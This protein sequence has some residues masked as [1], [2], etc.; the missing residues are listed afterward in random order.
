MSYILKSNNFS[1]NKISKTLPHVMRWEGKNPV[2]CIP[3]MGIELKV[4]RLLADG[5][6]NTKTRKNN[7][8]GYLSCG[9][10]LAPHKQAGIGNL[11]PEASTACIKACLTNTGMGSIFPMIKAARIARTMLFYNHRDWFLD[12]FDSELT[13]WEAKATRKN[14]LLCCRPNVFSD[15]PWEE[16]DVLQQHKNTA[17]YDYTKRRNRQRNPLPNYN[18]TF[19]RSESNT[20]QAIF[21][22]KH[23][24]NVAVVFYNDG[25]YT[26]NRAKHQVLPKTWEGFDVIDGD[27]TDLRFD[28]PQNGFVIG[29]RLKAP[30]K[31]QRQEAIDSGFAVAYDPA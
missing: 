2:C 29:L 24:Q 30:N 6:S 31:Q 7:G 23:K 18:L 17:F 28:D 10:S 12:R 4:S 15:I 1:A 5:D 16:F 25:K 21:K 9:L 20:A 3:S 11:C 14:L 19:S 27:T 26:G 8:K 22:L 13:R